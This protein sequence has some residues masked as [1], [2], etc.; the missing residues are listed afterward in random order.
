M[1]RPI[2]E[3]S[4]L[5]AK[6]QILMARTND[7]SPIYDARTKGPTHTPP[8]RAQTWMPE[9]SVPMT[10]ADFAADRSKRLSH[11]QERLIRAKVYMRLCRIHN[12][13][14]LQRSKK[15]E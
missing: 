12:V 4:T 1:E 7:D 9:L 11:V 3:T 13:H 2:E 8:M 14:L 15:R 5:A 6:A 10:K